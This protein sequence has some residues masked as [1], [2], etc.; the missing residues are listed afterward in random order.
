[1]KNI[2]KLLLVFII[3]P[4]MVFA[5]DKNTV[6]HPITVSVLYLASEPSQ[7]G[8]SLE[9][10]GKIHKGHFTSGIYN[11]S[12]AGITLSDNDV[13]I[14]GT[15]FAVEIGTRIYSKEIPK[16]WFFQNFISHSQTKFSELFFQG[17]YTYWSLFNSDLGY[18]FLVGNKISMEPSIGY[19]WKW[20]V[21]T[22]T[23]LDNKSIDNLSFRAGFKIG[24]KF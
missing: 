4:I 13:N 11:V 14:T 8:L 2:K 3:L 5:Q 10:E 15:G 17:K 1:M 23:D 12:A 16:G 20:E 6:P 9:I 24:Y 7:F 19:I 22:K 18:K 21:N